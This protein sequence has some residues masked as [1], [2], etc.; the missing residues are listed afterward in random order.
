MVGVDVAETALS[1]AREEAAARGAER[2]DCGVFHA[3]DRDER[4]EYVASLASVTGRGATV[5]VLCFSDV[6]PPDA[7]GRHP[8]SEAELRAAFTGGT[9]WG[10][11]SISPDRVETRFSAD[12]VSAWAKV[13]RA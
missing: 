8:V 3:F 2:S 1:I 6:G 12:G 9:G 10:V 11:G 4:R 7:V 13:E 5:Y